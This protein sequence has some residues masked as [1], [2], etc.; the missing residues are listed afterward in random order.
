M[1][2]SCIYIILLISIIVLFISI[3]PLSNVKEFKI[4]DYLKLKLEGGQTHIY[5]KGRR[6]QQCMY[7]LLNIPVDR[8][9]EY[10]EI[11]SIDEAAEKLDR[12]MEGNQNHIAGRITPEEEFQGHCSN[13]QVW[14][15]NGYDTRILHRNLAFPLLKRLS[16]VG[17]PMAKRVFSEE[18]AIRL[19]SKHPTVIQFLT[20]NG[21]LRYLN[22]DEFESI[23]EDLSPNF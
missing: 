15:E 5:V 23:F 4:N 22:H 13:I 7:L 19:G 2:L 21:Y 16:E 11:D 9:E 12:S 8:I 20:Q 1:A 6:F 14:A 18:I 10:D 3:K 17:D